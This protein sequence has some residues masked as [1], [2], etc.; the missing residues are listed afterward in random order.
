LQKED[1]CS[2]IFFS[3]VGI[4]IL[5]VVVLRHFLGVDIVPFIK[6]VAVRT[7]VGVLLAVAATLVCAF[8]FFLHFVSPWLYK[9]EHGSMEGYDEMSG[10]PVVCGFFVLGAGAL[11]PE[12]AFTGGFLLAL[13]ALDTNGVLWFFLQLLRGESV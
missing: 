1:V 4:V 11:M 9:K 12:S 10:L 8:N 3:V 6:P 7:V 2:I 13:F 5:V